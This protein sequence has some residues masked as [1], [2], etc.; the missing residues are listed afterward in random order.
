M[1][2]GPPLWAVILAC[3]IVPPL[4]CTSGGSPAR[5]V[6]GG[7]GG[8]GAVAPLDPGRKDL[9]RLSS[10]E[11]NATVRDVL[12]TKLEPANGS[13][14]GGEAAVFDNI[15]AVLHVDATQYQ[16]YFDAAKDLATDV[17][18]SDELRARFVNCALQDDACVRSSIGAPG[19]HLFRR[20]LESDELATY[21]RVYDSARALGDDEPAAFSLTLQ[22]LLS[23]A[24]ALYRIEVDPHPESA[25]AHP[26]GPF[27]LAARL[28]YFLWSSAPDDALLA[29]AAD[30]SLTS[31]DTLSTTVDRMLDDP[32]SERLITSFAGQWL[33]ARDVL[34]HPVA[35]SYSQWDRQ[36][37]Q[38][39]SQEILLYFAD[40]LRSGRSWFEL[41]TADINF[42]DGPLAYFYG[43]P[44]STATEVGTFERVEY[45]AD[46]RKGFFGLAGF[47]AVSSFD[48]R[49]SPSRRGLMIAGN[50]LCAE[51][52]PPP[53]NIPKLENEADGGADTATFNVRQMLEKHRSRPDCAGCHSLVDGYGLAL[54]QYDGIGLA[55][56]TY[57]DGSAIDVAVTLSDGTSFEGLDG[58]ADVVSRDP[59]FGACL[60]RK[61]LTY[62]LGRT[63]TDSDNPHLQRALD[64]WLSAGKTPSIRRLIHA[65]VASEAFR[66]RRGGK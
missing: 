64:E 39:A 35:P 31:L 55:R 38:S 14:R 61:L 59:R 30:G 28:S 8:D 11:Y 9:H 51:P 25:D 33:G 50:L 15:A 65:L 27:E 36:I 10:T 42:V 21:R 62:G 17:V 2:D 13:W 16:R 32:R 52:P 44:S 26:L 18:A 45:G 47:L 58:L 20:P 19:L 49:T 4:A 24:E 29:A 12:G 48:R 22:A 6:D 23:S 56:T 63:L 3:S 34:A 7:G 40:F 66:Y 41:P 37:A 60:A 46:R 43:M 54:E 1:I 57:S 53:P 5:P